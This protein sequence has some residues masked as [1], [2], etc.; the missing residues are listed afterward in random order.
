MRHR[1]GLARLLFRVYFVMQSLQGSSMREF[2]KALADIG[3]IRL[4]LA[5]GTLFRGFG[6]AVVAGSG[7]LAILTATAQSMLPELAQDHLWFLGTWVVTAVVSGVLIGT[8]MLART[9][10]HHGGLADDMLITAAE[11]FLPAAAAGAAIGGVVVRFAPQAAWLLPGSGRCWSR[12]GFSPRCGFAANHRCGWG[13]V[14]S[15]WNDCADRREPYGGVVT[16]C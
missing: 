11:H 5:S 2:E 15:G 16:L 8:E 7:V 3:E 1:I 9:R 12:S 13:M 6:P 10:R 14:L 4:Q